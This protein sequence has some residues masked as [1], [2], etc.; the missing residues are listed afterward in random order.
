MNGERGFKKI[1]IRRNII[2]IIGAIIV[3]FLSILIL[4]FLWN[5]KYSTVI[6]SCL[7]GIIIA[8]CVLVAITII[9][10]IKI[11]RIFAEQEPYNYQY[12]MEYEIHKRVGKDRKDYTAKKII[13]AKV[14]IPRKY[15]EWKKDL[16]SRNSKMLN[17]EDFY[18][19]LIYSLRH[20]NNYYESITTIMTPLEIGFMTVFLTV[21]VTKGGSA[22]D[23]IFAA[24][25]VLFLLMRELYNCK[26]EIAYIEDVIEVLC[27]DCKEGNIK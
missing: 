13:D 19:F 16:T 8:S 2:S 22:W 18:H 5:D 27:H 17:N 9:R 7:S 1:Y 4:S 11:C 20:A 14:K 23:A 3:D 10:I 15:T 25:V 26:N 21:Y 6:V 24:A 12:Y